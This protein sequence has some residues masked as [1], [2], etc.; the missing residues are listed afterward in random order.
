MADFYKYLDVQGQAYRPWCFITFFKVK[1]ILPLIV[2]HDISSFQH[3]IDTG[4]VSTRF[5]EIDGTHI[6]LTIFIKWVQIHTL[7]LLSVILSLIKSRWKKHQFWS[8]CPLSFEVGTV[9][10]ITRFSLLP[11]STPLYLN[12]LIIMFNCLYMNCFC[13]NEMS[14]KK[15]N[16]SKSKPFK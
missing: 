12:L 3:C 5:S 7:S 2:V 4:S 10:Q 14:Q 9:F 15:S 13:F 6:S 8:A 11:A 1:I 16:I